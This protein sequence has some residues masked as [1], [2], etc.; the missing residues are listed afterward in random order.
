M[1][2]V[3]SVWIRLPVERVAAWASVSQSDQHHFSL[4][5]QYVVDLSNPLVPFPLDFSDDVISTDKFREFLVLFV[6]LLVCS[7]LSQWKVKGR[8]VHVHFCCP[9][10]IAKMDVHIP[11]H[12]WL[13]DSGVLSFQSFVRHPVPIF[14]LLALLTTQWHSWWFCFRVSVMLSRLSQFPSLPVVRNRYRSLPGLHFYFGVRQ[15]QFS[16]C[17]FVCFGSNWI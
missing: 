12:K 15:T 5:H 2:Q 11:T 16:G 8:D 3:S 7:D 6:C 13:T 9:C 17:K 4:Q 14:S 1:T 10:Q